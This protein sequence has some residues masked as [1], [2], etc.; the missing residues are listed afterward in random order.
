MKI[1]QRLSLKKLTSPLTNLLTSAIFTG[2]FIGIVSACETKREMS[3]MHDATVEMNTRTEE[4]AQNSNDLKEQ[5]GELYDAL[6]QGDSLQL[7]R[8]ALERLVQTSDPANKLSEAAKYFM[9]FEVQLW[10]GSGPDATDEKRQLLALSATKEFFKDVLQFIPDD[11]RTA[12]PLNGQILT[13]DAGN[14]F[15]CLNALAAAMH[16][17]NPKQEL[18]LKTNASMKPVSM[19]SLVQEALL[20]KES[21]ESG[22]QDLKAVPGFVR[23]VLANEKEAIYLLQARYNYIP[24]VLLG[25]ST[26]IATSK[27]AAVKMFA[28]A[29]TLDLEKF[30][31]VQVYEF[32]E[33]LKAA[34]ETRD[35]LK[36]L[37]HSITMDAQVAR[38]YKNMSVSLSAKASQQKANIEADFARNLD[39]FKAAL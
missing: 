9:S 39:V 14:K 17:L 13:T 32:N 30:N 36:Q 31:T 4:L 29:W 11:Q 10:S 5:T 26:N 6:R 23:E 37:G 34:L 21:I 24:T 33:F 1:S 16:L 20:A 15:H 8:N 7:R 28:S 38:I 19:M 18:Y 3:E 25:R 27:L 2:I 12:S 35:L 22:A